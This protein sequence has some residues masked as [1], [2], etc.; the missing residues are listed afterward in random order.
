VG[1]LG[2]IFCRRALASP[3]SLGAGVERNF[4]ERN[5]VER[6]FVE[7]SCYLFLGGVQYRGLVISTHSAPSNSDGGTGTSE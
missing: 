5:F 6:N 7:C 1:I 3:A 2:C 4:V